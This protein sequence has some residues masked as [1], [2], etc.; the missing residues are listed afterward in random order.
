[1]FINMTSDGGDRPVV[2]DDQPP[3]QFDS[4]VDVDLC[5]VHLFHEREVFGD[6]DVV[7][8]QIRLCDLK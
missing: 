8:R 4:G 2:G 5:L 6:D 1:M 3:I 7:N